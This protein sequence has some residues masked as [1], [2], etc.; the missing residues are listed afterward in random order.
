MDKYRIVLGT[1]DT[2]VHY[3]MDD[4]D[5]QDRAESL[6]SDMSMDTQ[7]EWFVADVEKVEE[8]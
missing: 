8:E 6:A 4:E 5:A 1:Y 7:E 2:C 3:C